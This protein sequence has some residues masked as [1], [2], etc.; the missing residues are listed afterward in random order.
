[1]IGRL[2]FLIFFMLATIS[3]LLLRGQDKLRVIDRPTIAAE[4]LCNPDGNATGS[5][6]LGNDTNVSVPVHLSAGD[7]SSKSPNK[8]LLIQPTLTPKDT[9]LDSKQDLEV[10]IGIVGLY[11]DGDWQSTIENDGTDV[12]AVRIVRTS[13][14]FALSLDV[15]TPDAPELTFVKG[16]TG[17]FRLKNAD[18]R[19]YQIL[20]QYSIN[21]YTVGSTDSPALSKTDSRS[22]I[23]RWFSKDASSNTSKLEGNSDR[24]AALTLPPRGQQE[25]TFD[26]PL[27]WF[28]GSFACLF[29][30]KVA[31]GRLTVSMVS[32]QCP[33]LSALS[34]TF[35]VKTTLLTSSGARREGRADFWVFVFLAL[36][37]IFSLSLNSLLPNQMRRSK[38]KQRLSS[39][40]TRISSLSYDLASRLRVLVG[41]SQRLITDR[42]RNLTWTSPDFSGEMQDIEQAMTRLETRLQFLERLSMVRT[43]FIRLRAQVLPSSVIFSMEATFDKIVEVGEKSDPSDPDVQTAVSLIKNVEDQLAQG[44]LGNVDF[45]KSL[46][47]R[48]ATYK[49]DFNQENGRIGK[50]DTCKRIR[51]LVP[52]P[53]A[54]L[55]SV[56]ETKLAAATDVSSAQDYMDLDGRLFELEMIREYVDMVE[57][58]SSTSNLRTKITG[59]EGELLDYLSRG[60]YEAAYAAKLLL[61]EMT[62]GFFKEDIQ[63]EIE[64]ERV[65]IR[66]DRGE[67]RRYQPCEF[68]LEFL[69]L[70]LNTAYARQEWGCRWFFMLGEATLIEEGWVIT[71][72]FAEDFTYKL[73]VALTH[74][75]DGSVLPVPDVAPFS[76]GEIHLV[77]EVRR[78]LGEVF[79][80]VLRGNL[81]DAR[82]E[83]KKGR[84]RS[85][86]T[87]DYVRLA[88]AL[89]IALFGLIAGAKE[90]LLKL[91]LLPALLA[92]FMVGFGADQIKNLLTQKTSVPDTSSSH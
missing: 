9:N 19:E 60:S 55:E 17:H 13:P 29:K 26:P 50:T 58:L 42:L 54:R 47:G 78:Q 49:T 36:G 14:P 27:K 22:W 87:L 61:K 81:A 92:I 64:A 73:K 6:I 91:D 53:F 63:G 16:E 23:H 59:H 67:I 90:Q 15:A 57:G 37:G 34:R 51:V 68:R 39:A 35:N 89:V 66:V 4:S 82:K 44:I 72:Y 40:G 86:K 33:Q 85:G 75:V 12:G 11:E 52:G 43:N 41:Q 30:D 71:H 32:S 5:M 77:P 3:P 31:D 38:M 18:P 46:A 48:V 7:L 25:F 83:W 1:L 20:W 70:D 74:N 65:R 62:D 45:V 2:P 76:Q 21:G 69:K 56:D 10:K 88:M 24:N 80:F 79:K 84:R 28:G 8:Q